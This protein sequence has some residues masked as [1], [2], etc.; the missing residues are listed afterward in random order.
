MLSDS[1]HLMKSEFLVSLPRTRYCWDM[2][3][4]NRLAE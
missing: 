3:L 4:F 1:L 2:E